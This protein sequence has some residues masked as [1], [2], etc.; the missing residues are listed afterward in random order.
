MRRRSRRTGTRGTLRIAAWLLVGATVLWL[1]RTAVYGLYPLHYWDTL[2]EQ[3]LDHGLEPLLVAAVIRTESNWRIRAESAPGARGL[4]QVMPETARE[5]AGFLGLHDFGVDQL[6]EPE[7]NIQIGTYYLA[8]LTREFDG[9][10]VAALAAYNGGARHVR[11][12]LAEGRWNGQ[13]DAVDDIPF[14]ETREFVRQVL[15]DWAVY[16]Q[17]YRHDGARRR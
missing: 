15:R 17:L 16:G 12:W 2:S 10:V 11:T 6:F 3:A 5:V 14:P 13:A 8:A 7:V 9:N 1:V 4:M